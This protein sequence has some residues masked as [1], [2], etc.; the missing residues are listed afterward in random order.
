MHPESV[1]FHLSYI[2]IVYLYTLTNVVSLPPKNSGNFL[3]PGNHCIPELHDKLKIIIAYF[4]Y[5]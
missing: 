1:C 3:S 5:E 4:I 2:A